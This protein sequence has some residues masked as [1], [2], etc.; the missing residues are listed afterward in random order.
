MPDFPA[1]APWE[2]AVPQQTGEKFTIGGRTFY[3][4]TPTFEQ[5]MCIY[6]TAQ[7][8]GYA[9]L[10][11]IALDD[12]SGLLPEAAQQMLV[13]AYRSGKLYTLMAVL[14]TEDGVEWSED[15]IPE[16]EKLFRTTRDAEVKN[17]LID[18]TGKAIVYF[19]GSAVNSE[20]ISRTASGSPTAV[21]KSPKPTLSDDALAEVWNSGRMPRSSAPSP[22][23]TRKTRKS[24]SGGRSGKASSRTKRS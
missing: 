1:P 13:K 8:S 16:I 11:G 2:D 24:S 10:D 15:R 7:E 22:T 19:F 6:A 12:T 17:R 21:S 5:E 18:F 20:L 9:N 14:A 3:Y 23:T 4:D